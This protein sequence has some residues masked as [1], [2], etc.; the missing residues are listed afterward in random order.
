MRVFLTGASGW[1]GSAV[2][3]ELMAAGHSVIG[4]VR[5]KEKG[6]A[7]ALAGG[8][9]LVGSLGDRDVLRRGASDADGISRAL[10]S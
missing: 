4:L 5:S 9:A 7:L 8:T 6:A 3:G 2:A 1:I 10:A